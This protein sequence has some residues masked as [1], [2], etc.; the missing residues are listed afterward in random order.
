MRS[1][2]DS[3]EVVTMFLEQSRFD[4]IFYLEVWNY[5]EDTILVSP[6]SFYYDFYVKQPAPGGSLAKQSGQV[7]ARNPEQQISTVQKEISA[8]DARY[9]GSMMADGTASLLGLVID[10]A[11]IGKPT[12]DE[13]E[14]KKEHDRR[15]RE[16][17][18]IDEE[19]GYRNR[20]TSLERTRSM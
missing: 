14:R 7:R 3:I 17:E 5:S 12:T 4:F 20:I 18:R 1:N 15:E 16:A 19:A 2:D 6:D 8:E 13:E 9:A 10:V 11:S